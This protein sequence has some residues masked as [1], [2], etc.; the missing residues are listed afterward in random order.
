[1]DK[2]DAQWTELAARYR[3]GNV[4]ALK[5]QAW[6]GLGSAAEASGDVA[7][8]R[9]GFPVTLQAASGVQRQQG[10]QHRG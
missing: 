1:M 7:V 6:A 3:D 10:R 2:F 9:F 8:Q 5:R 4:V